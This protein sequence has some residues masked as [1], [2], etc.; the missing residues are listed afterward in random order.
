[1]SRR[2]ETTGARKPGK[3][4]KEK[5]AIASSS[6]ELRQAVRT[7]EW[8][9]WNRIRDS[10]RQE[11]L[12]YEELDG[13]ERKI[14][15]TAGILRSLDQWDEHPETD[16]RGVTSD[17]ETG[18]ETIEH[19]AW[20]TVASETSNA[21]HRLLRMALDSLL[22]VIEYGNGEQAADSMNS[23]VS[24]MVDVLNTIKRLSCDE[25][26]RKL[27]RNVARQCV[28]FPS[29]LSI[30]NKENLD[31][32]KFVL[33]DLELGAELPFSVDPRKPYT[34]Y[35]LMAM[36]VVGWIDYIRRACWLKNQW[37]SRDSVYRKVVPDLD[38]KAFLRQ[39]ETAWREVIEFHLDFFQAPKERQKRIA[40]DFGLEAEWEER[41]AHNNSFV[42]EERDADGKLLFWNGPWWLTAFGEFG[43]ITRM[44][45]FQ[46]MLKS[47]RDSN[48]KRETDL[49]NR[50]K[51]KVIA[52]A[53][54]LMKD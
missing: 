14:H 13:L 40:S 28:E 48:V 7:R 2:K 10:L 50:V 25:Q 18:H 53:I 23:L 17:A 11:C 5:A 3:K 26:K 19:K 12:I 43:E 15:S 42:K 44:R 45:E 36:R 30:F 52:A 46:N 16:Y 21:Q 49:Y 39:H 41:E 29:L 35:T 8:E 37:R 27:F 20:R 51:H 54:G 6:A 24:Q 9:E 34:P 32:E 47:G 33:E 31:S 4:P 38:K 1:M 22:S